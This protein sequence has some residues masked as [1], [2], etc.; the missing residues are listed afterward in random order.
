MK[1]YYEAR[2][3]SNK[4]NGLKIDDNLLNKGMKSFSQ[5]FA[6]A[7]IAVIL[8]VLGYLFESVGKMARS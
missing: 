1:Q 5:L 7:L 4:T 3:R 2:V 8:F 6:K